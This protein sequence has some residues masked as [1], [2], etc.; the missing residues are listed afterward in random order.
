LNY[1]NGQR[2]QA[3][4]FRLEQEYHMR[5]RRWL[6]RSL[7]KPGIAT[8]L[9]VQA[10]PNAPRVRVSPGLAIDAYGREI[11]LLEATEVNVTHDVQSKTYA[12]GPYL[13]VR[14]N[15]QTTSQQD[16][17]CTPDPGSGDKTATGGP[18]RILAEPVFECVPY[19]PPDETSGKIVLGMVILAKNC[20]KVDHIDTSIRRYV[21]EASSARVKQYALDGECEVAFIPKDSFPAPTPND[22]L[23]VIGR[24]Y[25]HIRGRQPNTVTLYLRA[26]E[27]SSLHYTELGLHNHGLT[28]DQGVLTSAPNYDPQHPEKYEHKHSVSDKF[29]QTTEYDGSHENHQLIVIFA[30]AHSTDRGQRLVVTDW[31]GL[32][33]GVPPIPWGAGDPVY[34]SDII[35]VLGSDD[36]PSMIS[37]G[38][39]QHKISAFDTDVASTKDDHTHT[40]S[41][42]VTLTGFGVSLPARSGSPLTFVDDLQIAIGH[43]GNT[44]DRTGDIQ[45][46]LA[47]ANPADWADLAGNPKKLGDGTAGHVLKDKG[48]GAIRLDFLPNLE[49]AEGEYCIELSVKAAAGNQPNGG[50]IHYNLYV[51]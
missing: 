27:F 19:P 36:H 15:E 41:P 40:F 4:D 46:Q 44:L 2:L 38:A 32:I 11:I 47:N 50:R 14:Y 1:F 28:V 21:G 7:Y 6:N 24:I 48:T 29:T 37:G 42:T 34:D 16:A 20:G 39:H 51:E 49:F 10:V 45:L 33:R 8:G 17:C 31:T 3:A 5:V 30:G 43:P 22:D 9:E 13:V 26:E 35:P 12:D 23:N 25:F 18:S